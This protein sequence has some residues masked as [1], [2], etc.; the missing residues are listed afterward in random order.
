MFFSILSAGLLICITYKYEQISTF[1]KKKYDKWVS[2]NEMVGTQYKKA[3]LNLDEAVFFYE[4]KDILIN[5]F[6]IKWVSSKIVLTSFYLKLLEFYNYMFGTK[7][8]KI[9]KNKYCL[10]YVV[11][12]KIYKM[13]L[14]PLRG[15]PPVLRV[16]DENDN[17]ITEKIEEYLGIHYDFHNIKYKPTFFD[18]EVMNFDM[19]CGDTL[20]F[21]MNAEIII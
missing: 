9:G 2:L 3:Y 5:R 1:A 6:M 15:P 16:S 13:I 11:H 7:I 12:N 8:R 10:T 18:C 19:L 14:T 21:G 4:K 17:D 20:T